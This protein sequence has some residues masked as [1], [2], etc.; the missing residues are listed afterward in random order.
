MLL[1][2]G[3]SCQENSE[4]DEIATLKRMPFNEKVFFLDSRNGWS[5]IY[6]VSYD[7]QGLQGD[8][9]L[10]P[11]AKIK[12]G[13]HMTISPIIEETN[14]RYLTIVNN[15][16]PGKIH[17]IN[18]N[19]ANDHRELDLYAHTGKGVNADARDNNRVKITQVDFDQNNFLFLAG[20]GGF[21]RVSADYADM[22]RNLWTEGMANT[23]YASKNTVWAVKLSND[24]GISMEDEDAEEYFESDEISNLKKPKFRGG[25]LLFTQNSNE[26]GGFEQ[27]KVISVTQ[28]HGNAALWVELEFGADSKA[29]KYN[30]RKLFNLMKVT[31]DPVSGR[32]GIGRVTGAALVGDNHLMTS[33][34]FT[35]VFEVRSLTGDLIASPKLKLA[36]G[37]DLSGWKYEL[38]ADGYFDHNWGDMASVQTF[39]KGF[40]LTSRTIPEDVSTGYFPFYLNAEI[41]EVEL[42]RPGNIVLNDYDVSDDNPQISKE[43][44]RNSANSDIADLR[45]KPFKFTSL[46]KNSGYM[47][48]K[49][50][51]SISVT[52]Q[53]RLQVVETSWG[54]LPSYDDNTLAFKAYPEQASVYVSNHSSRYIG[55]WIEDTNNWT[56]VGDAF[57]SSNLFSLNGISAFKWVKIVDDKSKTPDG[58]DVNFVATF[59]EPAPPVIV[60]APAP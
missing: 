52:P 9:I 4:V 57:I 3:F 24:G 38:N 58:Y 27:E 13:A 45:V 54:K 35:D 15:G 29:L 16:K 53:T 60:P 5:H 12:G 51:N 39:D 41:A 40:T 33:H 30:A 8:A 19:D 17:L 59:E 1:A 22:R 49:F 7:F 20:Q 44:R 48:L 46:G 26:S 31:N 14:T 25:D 34:H 55:D 36:P 10:T 42:Y 32:K 23:P 6:T 47:I 50:N 21:F 37:A 2:L 43:A 56:K 18:V 11:F 28:A